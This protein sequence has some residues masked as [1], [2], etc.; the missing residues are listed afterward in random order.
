MATKKTPEKLN[1]AHTLVPKHEILSDSE[2]KKVLDS[3][4]ITVTELPKIKQDDPAIKDEDAKPGQ[5]VRITRDS[6]SSGEAV[7][8][9][10]VIGE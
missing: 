9:R 5:V 4:N 10:T 8:Y 1:I 6:M 2:A 3:Y 7:F